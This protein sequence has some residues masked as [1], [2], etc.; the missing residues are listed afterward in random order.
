MKAHP[1]REEYPILESIVEYKEVFDNIS[2]C[3]FVVD[4]TVDDRFRFVGFNRAEE[5]AVGLS[6]AQV[7]GR[8]VEDLFEPEV[9]QQLIASYR[10]AVISSKPVHFD[11]DLDLPAGK[12]SFHTNLIPLKDVS[13]RISRIVGACIDITEFKKTKEETLARQ[14]L[15]SLGLL[16]GGVAHDFGNLVTSVLLETTAAKASVPEHSPAW[17]S[18]DNIRHLALQ[19][20]EI[21]RV[22]MAY[23]GQESPILEPLDISRLASETIDVL[24]SS[25]GRSISL[26]TNLPANLPAVRG[27]PAQI[28]QVIMNLCA[29]AKEALIDEQGVI[30]IDVAM[31]QMT[32]PEGSTQSVRGYIRL[33]VSDSGCGMTEEVQARIFDPFY[34]TKSRGRGLG[35][36]SVL[37][38]VHAHEGRIEVVSSPGHGSQFL[39]FLP[40]VA[41]TKSVDT[42]PRNLPEDQPSR[43]ITVLLV[44][45]E[46]LLRYTLA[47]VLRTK[48]IRVIEAADG[49]IALSVFQ[50]D[51]SQVDLVLLDMTLPGI[52]GQTVLSEIRQISPEMKVIL[53]TA[54]PEERALSGIRK[55]SPVRFLRKPYEVTELYRLIESMLPNV[56]GLT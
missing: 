38:I 30:S 36:A 5:E 35:L 22:L 10:R 29:N 52:P 23:A 2:A 4:V 33:E 14:R 44:E 17:K 16:A 50:T 46:K 54:Y 7:A 9:A 48:G 3:M 12:R 11:S 34:T 20:G 51:P 49:R 15:E 39:V 6:N 21:V 24:R 53:T 42:V 28:R 37:G 40:T 8:F 27:N 41:Q 25:L 45:D 47:K 55:E 19:A 26:R 13:G 32:A 43:P 1:H 31:V 18:I 56:S